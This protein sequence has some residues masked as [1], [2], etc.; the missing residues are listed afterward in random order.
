MQIKYKVVNF[1]A[2]EILQANYKHK[3][4]LSDSN[5][6]ATRINLKVSTPLKKKNKQTNPQIIF[7]LPDTIC[8]VG[9]EELRFAV[10]GG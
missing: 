8:N 10:E 9:A 7:T 6:T 3:D 5:N 4:I 1:S 2:L